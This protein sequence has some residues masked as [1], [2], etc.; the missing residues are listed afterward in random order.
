M[1]NNFFKRVIDIIGGLCA[2][3]FVLLALIIIGPI[4]YITDRG[5]IFY[6]AARLGRY[7]KAFKMFKLRSM[8][9]NAP[10]IRN[11]DGSTFNSENDPRVTK[12]GRFIRKTSLDEFPQFLNVLTGDMS[13]IGPRPDLLDDL[14]TYTEEE[15]MIL[16]VR[17]G[18]SGFNQVVNR[19][20]VGSKEKLQNDIY[21]V[22]HL[23]FW[24]DVKII[25]M[26]VWSVLFSNDIHRNNDP[27]TCSGQDN[28]NDN[29]A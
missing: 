1:Y 26:T 11:E 16:T 25:F 19:N 22:K 2:L 6:N 23:S 14:A 3:P 9:V 17:P 13:L 27:S 8:I 12:I 28:A 24:F 29:K 10:D 20:S 18:V 4:I 7:G 21:Y 5:P 15:K